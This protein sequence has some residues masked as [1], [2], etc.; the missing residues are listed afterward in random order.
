MRGVRQKLL[1]AFG[2]LLAILLLVGALS[3][4]LL[5][6]YSGTIE[7]IFRENYDSVV[8]GQNMK[9]AIEEMNDLAQFALWQDLGATSKTIDQL[10]GQFEEN[11]RKEAGNITLPGERELV[12]HLAALWEKYRSSIARVLSGGGTEAERRALYRESL[13][14]LSQQVKSDAQRVIGINLE[15]I[16]SIDGQVRQSAVRSRWTMYALLA[17]GTGLAILLFGT[18]SRSILRPLRLLTNSAREIEQGNL[19][20]VVSVPSRDEVGQLAEAFNSM[21]ARLREFRRSD[22]ARLVRTQ[23]TTQL[24]I[25]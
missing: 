23:R 5:T 15:N 7:R 2:G 13:V 3:L 12:E 8:Y 17:A 21:A 24:A 6:R 16:V 4:V 25:N 14:P 11:L 22:R 18:I 9:E 10:R 1:F 19:D 20:L